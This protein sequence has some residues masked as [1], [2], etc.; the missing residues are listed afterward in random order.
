MVHLMASITLPVA[1]RNGALVWLRAALHRAAAV[2]SARAARAR[3]LREL[4]EADARDLRDLGISA[5]D[6]ESIAE[7]RFRR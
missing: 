4:H 3:V 1:H 5:C 2:Q 6:F 7:G